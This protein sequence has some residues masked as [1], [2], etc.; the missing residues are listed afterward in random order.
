MNP[1]LLKLIT[2]LC[3]NGLRHRYR[4]LT[5]KP[6][7]PAAISFEITHECIARC[8]MCN[9]WKIPA[10]VPNLPI[11]DWL[12][13]LS[14][15]VLDE[16]R[17]L[18]V[19]GGEPFLRDDLSDL[20]E[21]ICALK[22]TNLKKLRAVAVTTNGFL[23]RRV[24]TSVEDIARRMHRENIE[25][26]MVCAMDAA[27]PVHEKIRRV[28]GGWP[29]LNDTIQ[30]LIELRRRY[31]NLIIGLKT[32]ILPLNI[33]EL[34]GIADYA[35]ANRL[36]TI[37]SPCII[38]RGRYLNPDLGGDMAFSSEDVAKMI[39]FYRGERSDWSYHGRR[40]VDY[41]QTGV[42]RKPCTCGYNYFF[43]R[44]NGD[45][46]LCPLVDRSVGNIRRRSLADVFFSDEANRIRKG[47]GHFDEC[48]SCTEPG[49]ERFSL[50]MEGF[51]YLSL[52]PKF[53]RTAFL[54]FHHHM[55]LDKYVG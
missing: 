45:V 27:G 4:R 55:G 52:L 36:F 17:E 13:L 46:Y 6:G 20:F 8:I 11:A 51:S 29:K 15:P 16:L 5:G 53:G 31:P 32:T 1:E 35:E 33:D 25:L 19:T 2:Q 30:G 39:R 42:M 50:P 3:R 49:L 47:V 7:K 22:K 41:F 26:V 48:R 37:M 21:G 34:D 24:V 40:L 23:T 28:K 44:S 43:V 9:I 38:T 14:S 10:R 54:E 18:D 12:L